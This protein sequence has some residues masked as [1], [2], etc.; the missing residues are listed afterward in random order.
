VHLKQGEVKGGRCGNLG[1]KK[2]GT[3]G[4]LTK[5]AAVLLSGKTQTGGKEGGGVPA[6]RKEEEKGKESGGGAAAPF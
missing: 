2:G 1:S 3:R 4:E 5:E 6:V